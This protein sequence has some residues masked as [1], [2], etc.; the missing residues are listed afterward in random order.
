MPETLTQ[1]DI[2]SKTDPSVAKQYDNETPKDQ[3]IQE[4]FKLVDSKKVCMLNTYRNGVGPVGRSMAIAKRTGPDFLFLGNA[5]SKKFSDLENNKEVQIS[6]QDVKTQDWITVTG[7]AT[8]TSN[9]DPRIKDIW[10]QGTRAWFGDLGDGKH[11]GG[12][13]D[14]RMS[15]I[16]IKSSYISYYVTDVGMLGLAKEVIGAAV[17]GGVANTGKLRELHKEDIEKARSMQ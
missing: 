8:T 17:T 2:N 11:T 15:L 13:E 5:H 16:E 4:F 9:S 7:T 10:S 12:P 6:I 3:Q 14:P 1:N